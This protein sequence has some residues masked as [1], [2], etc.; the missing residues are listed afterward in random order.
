MS[1]GVVIVQ[2]LDCHSSQNNLDVDV[3]IV[4]E[5]QEKVMRY[6]MSIMIGLG[7]LQDHSAVV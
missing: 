3:T 1:F 2:L 7:V 6:N 5:K 4:F